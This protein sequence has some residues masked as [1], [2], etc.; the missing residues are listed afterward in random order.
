MLEVGRE[1]VAGS[2]DVRRKAVQIKLQELTTV[3]WPAGGKLDRK[4]AELEQKPVGSFLEM[5]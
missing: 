5:C 3:L 2:A 4:S 1:F